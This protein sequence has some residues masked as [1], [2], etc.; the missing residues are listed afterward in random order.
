MM[1]WGITEDEIDE[2]ALLE[3]DI[4]EKEGM[5][6]DGGTVK[7]GCKHSNLLLFP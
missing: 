4:K 2:S 1:Q 7:C 3:A 6:W 5:E